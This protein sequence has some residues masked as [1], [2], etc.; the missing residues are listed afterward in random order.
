MINGELIQDTKQLIAIKNVHQMMYMCVYACWYVW[1]VCVFVHTHIYMHRILISCWFYEVALA[2]FTMLCFSSN[3]GSKTRSG[4][5]FTDISHV[6]FVEH[7]CP[8]LTKDDS[9]ML[10]IELVFC[11]SCLPFLHKV[12]SMAYDCYTHLHLS[13]ADLNTVALSSV[14]GGDLVQAGVYSCRPWLNACRPH[15]PWGESISP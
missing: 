13:V 12:T 7:S 10:Y 5:K 11:D 14:R 4:Q 1:Y 3:V 6:F 8:Q 2:L 15:G 9:N